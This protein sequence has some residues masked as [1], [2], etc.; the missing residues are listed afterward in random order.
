MDEN[1]FP[2][3]FHEPNG[4]DV[5]NLPPKKKLS[6]SRT[7]ILI[8][9]T[10]AGIAKYFKT[11]VSV[12]RVIAILSLLL[13]LWSVAAYFI[14]SLVIPNEIFSTELSNDEIKQQK[15]INY[16]T[17]TGG[18]MMLSGFYFGFSSLGFRIPT[19]QFILPSYYILPV[20]LLGLGIF[21]FTSGT[22]AVHINIPQEKYERSRNDRLLLGVCGGLGK[23]LE[24]DSYLIRILFVISTAL[25]LGIF[26]IVYILFGMLTHT[27]YSGSTN[28]QH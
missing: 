28:E 6:R 5:S 17:I 23:Y 7:D 15:K 26:A 14:L 24:V 16:R 2:N 27:K 25:T 13:G 20:L 22:K 1:N 8:T 18:L 4:N 11:D 19:L 12:I 10:C 3:I 9:G 21:L